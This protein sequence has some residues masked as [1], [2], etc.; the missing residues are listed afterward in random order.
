MLFSIF[1]NYCAAFFIDT[2][3]KKRLLQNSIFVAAVLCNI[4]I[5]FFFKYIDFFIQN[6]NFIIHSNIPK[7]NIA[8]PIGISFFTF[9]S[10][11][12]V[13]DVKRKKVTVQKNPLDLGL[14]ISFFPQ[15]IAGPIVRYIDINQQLHVRHTGIQEFSEGCSRFMAGFSKKILLA[16]QLAPYIDTIFAQNGISAPS[17]WF[18]LIAYTLQIYFDFS[19][20]S[21][22]AIGLGK[23]FGFD[24]P[25]N[26]DYPYIAKSVKEFWRRWHISLSHWFRDYVYIPLGGSRHGTMRTYI[27]LLVVWG[28]TGFWHGAS[29]NFIFWGLY[30][31]AFLALERFWWK[32]ILSK[33]P[34]A[35][36]HFYTIS[37]VSI[38]WLLFRAEGPRAVI[39]YARSLFRLSSSMW[40]DFVYIID[41]KCIFFV[42][43]GII[44]SIPTKQFLLSRIGRK[45]DSVHN[46]LLFTTFVVAIAFLLGTGFSP[47]LYFRF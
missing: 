5:L 37:V 15:L 2:F 4:G 42:L 41:R 38:G 18:G 23:M 28:L 20:Y 46:C 43:L 14:Y 1:L 30:Y 44:F 19:G 35:V 8:M 32:K 25:E 26:F 29:W 40:V 7:T 31:F 47:F 13:I 3:H 11:S 22:M 34:T 17:A 27:N 21:D 39:K 24:F 16:D 45:S 10:L 9:Q 33:L 12:Y 6:V 36:Q